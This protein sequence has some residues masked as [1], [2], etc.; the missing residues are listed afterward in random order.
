MDL[1]WNDER[2]RKFVTNVGLITSN[3]PHGQNVMAA[4][5][6][7]HISYSPSL[8]AVCINPQD[9]T[10]EN[11]K[12]TKE[13]GINLCAQDQN[14]ISSIAGGSTGKKV[15]KIALL[16]EL[17]VEFYNAEKINTL[18]LKG[19]SMNAECKLSAIEKAGDHFACVGKVVKISSTEKSPLVYHNGKYW[20]LGNQI[21]KP[22][23]NEFSR[24][25]SLV[26]KYT[27]K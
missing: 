22:P 9:A 5:W 19:A 25:Q 12:S 14:I 18:M 1:A 7:H 10:L 6:T 16:K 27:K 8:I 3:G 23:P 20:E 26:E 24:L 13:F 11:I 15:D 4:E 17:G 21:S 2:T